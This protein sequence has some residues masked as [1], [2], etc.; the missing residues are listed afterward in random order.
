MAKDNK[1]NRFYF[2]KDFLGSPQGRSIRILSEYYGPLQKINENKIYDTIVFFGSARIKSREKAEIAL[3][4]LTKSVSN[5][6]KKRIQKDLEMSR[7][8]EDARE[9]ANRLTIWS[10]NL[11]SKKSR[12]IITSGGGGG[13]MGG[14]GSTGGGGRAG[15]F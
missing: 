12:Y 1:K 7:F 13:I 14:G 9:L 6:E 5:K 15:A 3:K 4:Q 8:Y 2:N 10:K 11:K